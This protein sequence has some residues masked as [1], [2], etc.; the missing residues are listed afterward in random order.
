MF[1]ESADYY[2]KHKDHYGKITKP[3]GVAPSKVRGEGK[4]QTT[5]TRTGEGG[6]TRDTLTFYSHE[7][8][9]ID[10]LLEYKGTLF[11][12]TERT[13]NEGHLTGM[14]HYTY[15]GIENANNT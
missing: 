5:N 2:I 9:N 10:N 7:L 15:T 8:L 3:E 1:Y 6:T 4:I 13:L 12:I 11:I 14:K